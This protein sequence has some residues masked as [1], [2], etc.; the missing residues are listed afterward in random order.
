[1]GNP[2]FWVAVLVGGVVANIFDFIVMGMMMAPVF[3]GIESMRQ[4]MNPMWFVI[5]D[6][7]AVFVMMVMYDRV[8]SSFAPGPKGGAT[9]GAYAGLLASFPLWIFIHLMFKGFPYGLSWGLTAIGICWGAIVG[10]VLGAMYK[11]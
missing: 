11:K 4:D 7:I 10:S 8:Y 2:K 1:M 5:G 3:A 9:F 6:F